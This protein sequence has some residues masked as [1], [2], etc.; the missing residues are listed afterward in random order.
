MDKAL[1]E[2]KGV[3]A[4]LAKLAA[5]T[6]IQAGMIIAQAYYLAAAI[7]SLY[8]GDSFH[9]V[10]SELA[11]FF[12]ALMFRQGV[13]VWK[14]KIVFYFAASASEKLRGDFLEKLF[15]LG[16]RFI[17]KEGSGQ[18][19]T[20]VIEGI[21]KYRRYLE[22]YL[23]KL[24]NMVVTPVTIVLFIMSFNA[25]SAVILALAL[26]LLIIFLVLLGLTAKTK[27]DRQYESY[28]LL[29]NHFVDSLRGMETLKYLGLGKSHVNK[30]AYVSEQYRKATM[31]SLKVAFLSSFAL[32]FFTMLS[33]ATVAVFLGLDLINGGMNLHPALTIL[34]LAPEYFLPI[35]ELGSDYHATLDGKNAG[36]KV[37]KLLELDSLQKID[38]FVPGWDSSTNFTIKGL[39]VQFSDDSPVALSDI[40]LHINGAKKIGIT[41]ASGAGK[42]TLID[43]LSGFLRP[44]SGEYYFNQHSVETLAAKNWQQ[45]LSYIP[46]HP[47]IFHDSVL[48]NIRFYQP[49]AKINEVYEAASFAGLMDLVQSLPEGMNTVIGDGGRNLSGGQEQRIALA[50]AF[51]GKRSIIMLDEPTAHLDIETELELRDNMLEFFNGKLVF[52]AT[53]R[54]HWMEEM[55]EIIVL[56]HGRIVERG[57]HKQLLKK[58]SAYYKLVKAQEGGF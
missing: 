49:D 19:V 47:Y 8:G 14:K 9:R 50:R 33:I 29:S 39:N 32:D 15:Q 11:V 17:K 1:F 40:E 37:M 20:M 46:Q 54:L 5:L 10:A 57:N 41:G 44:V 31:A 28:H 18:T 12:V 22:L 21:S 16:P 52:L 26:P 25:R 27:A 38:T 42:S 34:I 35:R 48:N 23:L 43:A 4:V 53:H 36:K 30:I 58:K 51:L 45:Q 7:S 3:G 24:I 2:I 13:A 55:D 56:E 6:V